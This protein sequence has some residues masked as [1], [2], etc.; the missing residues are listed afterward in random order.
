MQNA[1]KKLNSTLVPTFS[2]VLPVV[3]CPV[4]PFEV[5]PLLEVDCWPPVDVV[6][7]GFVIVTTIGAYSVLLMCSCVTAE[8][9]TSVNFQKNK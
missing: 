9:V 3:E 6:E 8:T 2:F 7:G 1:T 5:W 4:C